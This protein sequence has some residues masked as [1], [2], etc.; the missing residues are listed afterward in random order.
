VFGTHY[1]EAP[2]GPSFIS[3]FVVGLDLEGGH[4]RLVGLC[5]DAAAQ[6]ILRRICAQAALCEQHGVERASQIRRNTTKPK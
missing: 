1:A 5:L 4:R 2:S 3:L 6:L